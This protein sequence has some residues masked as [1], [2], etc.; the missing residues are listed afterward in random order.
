MFR[1]CTDGSSAHTSGTLP[2]RT[3]GLLL[4]SCCSLHRDIDATGG[5]E[6]EGLLQLMRRSDGVKKFAAVDVSCSRFR[7]S[8]R[9]SVNGRVF[10][11]WRVVG[12][13]HGNPYRSPGLGFVDDVVRPTVR[14]R[15]RL[16]GAGDAER[17]RTEA[18]T[19]LVLSSG[20]I[21]GSSHLHPPAHD[22]VCS[23]IDTRVIL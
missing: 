14:T 11:V 16:E 23:S 1:R 9:V 3:I 7:G 6:M 2:S 21:A 18:S 13:G 12:F 22:T 5:C 4:L 19:A 10:A 17:G 15:P 8:V 20:R